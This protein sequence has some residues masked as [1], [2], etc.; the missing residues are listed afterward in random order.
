MKSNIVCLFYVDDKIIDVTDKHSIAAEIKCPGV[1]SKEHK[2]IGL[3]YEGEVGDF[4][5]I[6]IDKTRK[7]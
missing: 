4:I 6:R 7:S 5:E 2:K 1:S 3:R